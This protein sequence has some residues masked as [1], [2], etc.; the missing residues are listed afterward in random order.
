M[1]KNVEE[2]KM[3]IQGAYRKLKSYYYYNKTQIKKETIDITK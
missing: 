3:M 2:T 1:F